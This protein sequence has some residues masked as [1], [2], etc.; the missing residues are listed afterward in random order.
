MS[1]EE[2]N[3]SYD[4]YSDR[5]DEEDDWKEEQAV[6]KSSESAVQKQK[7]ALDA[8]LN[9]PEAQPSN[10]HSTTNSSNFTF[11]TANNNNN[12]KLK[13]KLGA[14]NTAPS[15][16]YESSERPLKISI[17]GKDEDKEDAR[18]AAT[19]TR[20][21]KRAKQTVQYNEDQEQPEEE[22]E[23]YCICRSTYA[24]GFMISCDNCSEWYPLSNWT[25]F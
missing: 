12:M 14:N 22:G 15:S 25:C 13:I 6:A 20:S 4:S 5:D 23:Q 16:N 19:P 7:M 17:R 10:S 24:G 11:P 1:T 18:S 2:Q 9:P 21:S 8:L 3:D